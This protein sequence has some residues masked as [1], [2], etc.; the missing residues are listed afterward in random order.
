M[1]KENQILQGMVKKLTLEQ[2][3]A[4]GNH[5]H[6]DSIIKQLKHKL[7]FATHQIAAVTSV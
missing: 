2:G 6:C 1:I 4:S 7:G 3:K 5:I